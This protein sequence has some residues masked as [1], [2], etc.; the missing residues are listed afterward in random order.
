[1]V[2]FHC[3]YL[4]LYFCTVFTEG[5]VDKLK[6]YGIPFKGLGEGKHLFRFEIGA[7]FFELFEESLVKSGD[8][9]AVVELEKSSALLTI[10]FNI[11]GVVESVCDRCLDTLEL[12][13][14]SNSRMYVKF[15]EEYDEPSEELIVLPHDAHDINVAQLLYE[16][17]C[18]SLPIGHVHPDDEDGNPTCDPEMLDK[19]DQYLVEDQHEEEQ[20][21]DIDPR[22]EAL[23]NIVDNNK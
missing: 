4:F 20:E 17:I 6:D 21:D 3:H 10:R 12:P 23:R 15:G 18:V 2:F 7:P 13:V 5:K 16:F 22:W 1:M 9:E 14:E 19:L 11:S 8:V